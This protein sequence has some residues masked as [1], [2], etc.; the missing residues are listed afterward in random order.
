MRTLKKYTLSLILFFASGLAWAADADLVTASKALT[1]KMNE[2]PVNFEKFGFADIRQQ[3]IAENR[4]FVTKAFKQASFHEEPWRAVVLVIVMNSAYDQNH[5]LM[6]ENHLRLRKEWRKLNMEIK[7]LEDTH[8]F[9]SQTLLAVRGSL[10][11]AFA[12]IADGN[13]RP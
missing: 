9:D 6:L 13:D 7:R 4:L 5:D 12:E 1:S 10:A 3:I 2:N 8:T 11:V